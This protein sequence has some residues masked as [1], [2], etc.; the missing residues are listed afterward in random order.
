MDDAQDRALIVA[1]FHK[2]RDRIGAHIPLLVNWNVFLQFF[3]I[4]RAFTGT[5]PVL[6][7]MAHRPSVV[8]SMSV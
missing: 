4:L 7:G 5:H 8:R 1:T 6:R 2:G 3:P